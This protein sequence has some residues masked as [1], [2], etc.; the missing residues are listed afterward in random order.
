MK[1]KEYR[2][3]IENFGKIAMV[4][5]QKG[6]NFSVRCNGTLSHSDNDY[7][8]SPVHNENLKETGYVAITVPVSGTEFHKLLIEACGKENIGGY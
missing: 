5:I 8:D 6:I 3:K 1:Q 4:L 7:L 2:I